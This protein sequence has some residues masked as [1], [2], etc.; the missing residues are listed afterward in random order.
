MENTDCRE[1]PPA[2]PA[3]VLVFKVVRG[4]INLL[5]LSTSLKLNS[6]SRQNKG[7][8]FLDTRLRGYD[9]SRFFYDE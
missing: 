1:K 8:I 2:C 3:E 6:L 5:W 9:D 7:T 4:P